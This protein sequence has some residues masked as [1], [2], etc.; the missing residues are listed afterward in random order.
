[1]KEATEARAGLSAG[2]IKTTVTPETPAAATVANTTH[3]ATTATTELHRDKRRKLTNKANDAPTMSPEHA[4]IRMT[5]LAARGFLP[6]PL[7]PDG[8]GGFEPERP[9][10]SRQRW[11]RRRARGRTM[12]M[13]V[14]ARTMTMTA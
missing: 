8:L 1:M 11:R 2:A 9:S 4:S 5:A 14:R 12:K 7:R 3:T 13:R 10:P 6:A